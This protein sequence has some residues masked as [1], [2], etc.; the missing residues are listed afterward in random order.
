MSSTWRVPPQLGPPGKWGT[1]WAT[2]PLPHKLLCR[3]DHLSVRSPRTGAMPPAVS[4]LIQTTH[5]R[6]SSATGPRPQPFSTLEK[7]PLP[8][9][10]HSYAA[11]SYVL[12]R[13]A[14]V[15]ESQIQVGH[16]G[17][18]PCRG[19]H[20]CSGVAQATR[21]HLRGRFT[22]SI[23]NGV[24]YH[25]AAQKTTPPVR[26]KLQRE[27]VDPRAAASDMGLA[28]VKPSIILAWALR[29]SLR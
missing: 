7:C 28:K 15:I 17:P 10:R 8:S 23:L 20:L 14:V 5:L 3:R 2:R 6:A 26:G 12:Q 16:W 13:P 29:P 9:Q 27:R 1:Q 22:P 4:G 25:H 24:Q 18:A 19:T 21:F 11:G